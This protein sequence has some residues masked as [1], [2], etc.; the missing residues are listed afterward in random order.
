MLPEIV[1]DGLDTGTGLRSVLYLYGRVRARER[2]WEK[3]CLAKE[4]IIIVGNPY[5]VS[6]I[7]Y[8]VSRISKIFT[9]QYSFSLYICT[10]VL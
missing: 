2:I 5:P 9:P 7:L 1:A 10:L 8:Q 4:S 3:T 6:G